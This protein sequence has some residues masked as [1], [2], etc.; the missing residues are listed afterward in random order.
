MLTI[1][2]GKYFQYTGDLPVRALFNEVS[3]FA[4][5]EHLRVEIHIQRV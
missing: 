4:H 5:C 2:L 3:L 1:S